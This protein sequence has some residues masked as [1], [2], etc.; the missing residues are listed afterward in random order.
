MG[1]HLMLLP[2]TLDD[3]ERL[4]FRRDAFETSN[5]KCC[6]N[7]DTKCNQSCGNSQ[8]FLDDFN[9]AEIHPQN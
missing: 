8:A 4:N 7:I 2:F 9:S 1:F 6:G 5:V 3:L